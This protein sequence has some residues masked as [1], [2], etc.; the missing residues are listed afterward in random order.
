MQILHMF[1]KKVYPESSTVP[2]KLAD[3]PPPHKNEIKDT[4][5]YD[6]GRHII[7][8]NNADDHHHHGMLPVPVP[9]PDEE[10]I[11]IYPQGSLSKI[12]KDQTM[13]CFRSCHSNPP[14]IAIST[15]GNSTAGTSTGNRECWIKTDANCT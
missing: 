1:H 12:S 2:H 13:R 10:D 3:K 6:Q 11:I 5:N 9:V 7:N 14:Q 4:N 15:T 8:I